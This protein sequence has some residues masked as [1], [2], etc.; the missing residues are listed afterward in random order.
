MKWQ[1]TGDVQVP[2]TAR[3]RRAIAAAR[4]REV[5][6]VERHVRERRKL[7]FRLRLLRRFSRPL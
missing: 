6:A 1:G 3:V 2:P 7:S 4:R 5:A